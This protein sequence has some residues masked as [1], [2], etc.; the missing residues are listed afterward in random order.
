MVSHGVAASRD[1]EEGFSYQTAALGMFLP[2][3][4][5]GMS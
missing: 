1:F 4:A 3:P 5:S 2:V